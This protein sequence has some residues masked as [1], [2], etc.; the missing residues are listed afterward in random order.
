MAR[1][2]CIS[3]SLE[4]IKHRVS[5]PVR[6]HHCLSDMVLL[7]ESNHTGGYLESVQ[8]SELAET[9]GITALP[10]HNN[11]LVVSEP[12]DIDPQDLGKLVIA[13][14]RIFA[15]IGNHIAGDELI[16]ASSGEFTTYPSP[17]KVTVFSPI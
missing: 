4:L 3:M 16:G 10:K 12:C 5:D 6:I 9:R 2:I 15:G 1:A 13:F 8:P 17:N 14:G 11:R 7:H